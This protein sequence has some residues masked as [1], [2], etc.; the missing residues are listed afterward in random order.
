[1]SS[2]WCQYTPCVA[3]CDQVTLP[4]CLG[5]I[6]HIEGFIQYIMA[7]VNVVFLWSASH[8]PPQVSVME[9]QQT[10]WLWPTAPRWVRAR[11]RLFSSTAG[12][13]PTP[14][15]TSATAAAA[16]STAPPATAPSACSCCRTQLSPPATPS[17][18]NP[19]SPYT[20]A[21][22]FNVWNLW[23]AAIKVLFLGR[24]TKDNKCLNEYQPVPQ[25]PTS[26]FVP[27]LLSLLFS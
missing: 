27:L 26:T 22:V 4:A 21:S 16:S 6:C 19:S 15:A 2:P 7:V 11:I 18:V 20:G 13:F 9:T 14:P 10:T 25:N 23:K 3:P 24:I 5:S 1:M 12:R 17:Y 8:H